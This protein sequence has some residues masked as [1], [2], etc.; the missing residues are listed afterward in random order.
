MS[1]AVRDTGRTLDGMPVRE[2][3]LDD[4]TLRVQLLTHGARLH[5]LRLTGHDRPLVVAP[6]DLAAYDRLPFAYFGAIVGPVANRISGARA[7]LDGVTHRFAANERG[8]TTLHGGPDGPHASNWDIDGATPRSVTFT[9]NLRDGIGGFPGNRAIAARYALA[10]DGSLTLS[11]IATTDAPTWMNF[12]NHAFWN[13]DGGPDLAGHTLQVDADR[14]LPTDA[15]ALVTGEVAQVGGTP[16]DFR[17]PRP[18][19]PGTAPGLD[20]NFCLADA[21][22]APERALELT[23]A[24]G[25]RMAVETTEPGV[26]VFDAGPFTGDGAPTSLSGHPIGAH[27]GLAIEPQGWPDAPNQPRFPSVVVRPP[28]TYRQVSKFRFAAP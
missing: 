27:A 11:I 19:G 23:G 4:G 21:S 14:Y 8:T 13:L 1:D 28:A 5:D 12:A 6:A 20:H 7:E 15:G 9:L 16:F 18:V 25:L 2:V 17:Q 24:T 3:T 26:Q 22:R 10:G